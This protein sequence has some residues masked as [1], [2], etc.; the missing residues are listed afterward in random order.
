MASSHHLASIPSPVGAEQQPSS[1]SPLLQHIKKRRVLFLALLSAGDNLEAGAL[2]GRS[3][4]LGLARRLVAA[5]VLLGN[6]A[7]PARAASSIGGALLLKDALLRK[8]LAADILFGKV[9]AIHG[10]G[11]GVDCIGNQT[12]VEGQGFQS[13]LEDG[14]CRIR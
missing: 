7:P 14:D 11:A 10:G 9:S 12:S 4:G 3:V 6:L 13:R 5:A 8:L 2:H 1:G